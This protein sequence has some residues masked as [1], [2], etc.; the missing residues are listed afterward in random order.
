MRYSHLAALFGLVCA[1]ALAVPAAEAKYEKIKFDDIKT[2]TFYRGRMTTDS[3]ALRFELTSSNSRA[4]SSWFGIIFMVFFCLIAAAII[5][6]FLDACFSRRPVDGAPPPY[7]ATDNKSWLAG[8]L[9]AVGL[10]S[11]AAA[12]QSRRAQ[13]AYPPYGA[14]GAYGTYDPLYHSAL[15][16]NRYGYD[17]HHSST[18]MHT[19]S[20]FGDT[21]NR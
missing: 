2:L 8:G 7:S 20:G 13:A 10:G 12:W 5:I 16:A 21:D 17:T 11:L 1:A 3:C 14:Y 19:S 4:E 9:A 18:G 6:S 15:G